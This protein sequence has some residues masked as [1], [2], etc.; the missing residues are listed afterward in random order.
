MSSIGEEEPHTYIS[1]AVLNYQLEL[2]QNQG[3]NPVGPEKSHPPILHAGYVL[4]KS[5]ARLMDKCGYDTGCLC[6]P[7]RQL[8]VLAYITHVHHL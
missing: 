3:G 2:D 4:E 1:T 5:L 6:R 7:R 8:S